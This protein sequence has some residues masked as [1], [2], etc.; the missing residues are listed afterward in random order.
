MSESFGTRL[1][2]RRER[3]EIDL[4]TIAE[5]TK[6]K[7]SLLEALERDDVSRWPTG[8]FRR[9][10]MR[11][12]ARAIGLEPDIVVREFLELHPDQT[13]VMATTGTIAPDIG[14][15]GGNGGPPTRLRY[16]V[17]AAIGSLSSR[18]R[19][20]EKLAP[21]ARD[22]TGCPS[23]KPSTPFD[24]DHVAAEHP[25]QQAIDADETQ[26]KPPALPELDLPA[27]AD[28]CTRFGL[29]DDA[30]DLTP[31]IQQAASIL[32]A[33]GLIVWVWNSPM[34]ELLP[35]VAHGYSEKIL[36]QLPRLGPDT[37]N[38]TAAAFRAA[39][40]RVVSSSDLANGALAVPL[41]RTGGCAGVFAIELQHHREQNELVR[42]VATILAAQLATL[43]EAPRS[44]EVL[45]RKPA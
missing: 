1:R 7:L 23:A 28:L 4:T 5:Q 38:A 6:I 24:A 42:A 8:I 26:V 16:H 14:T 36:A 12:Y 39:E 9:A 37:N 32:D 22:P 27:V 31:L 19:A 3:Q 43:L 17:G 41:M 35:V 34:N 29:V 45:N 18:F 40:T 33:V 10:F 11:A 13:E 20:A 44:I 25:S 15:A 30:N 21:A 2:L